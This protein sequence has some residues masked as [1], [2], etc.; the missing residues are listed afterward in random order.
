MLTAFNG[1][2]FPHSFFQVVLI[3]SY[4]SS[5]ISYANRGFFYLHCLRMRPC[6]TASLWYHA[7]SPI[8]WFWGCHDRCRRPFKLTSFTLLLPAFTGSYTSLMPKKDRSM[9]LVNS[10]RHPSC[11]SWAEYKICCIVQAPGTS[12]WVVSV[13]LGIWGPKIIKSVSRNFS[14]WGY[15]CRVFV[16]I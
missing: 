14:I 3:P 7:K 16:D 13:N 1:I 11:C 6:L 10:W 8:V 5:L 9:T 15:F 4:C 2:N 12:W